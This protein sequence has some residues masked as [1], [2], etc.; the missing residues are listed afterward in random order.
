MSDHIDS[1]NRIVDYFIQAKKSFEERGAPKRAI[2]MAKYEA[3][4]R[5]LVREHERL[6]GLTRPIPVIEGDELSDLPKELLAELSITKTDELEEQLITVINASGGTA[7]ID[8]IL[9][10]LF[11]KFKVVQTRRYLQNKL[12]RMVQKEMLY[13]VSGK[14]GHYSTSI[15]TNIDDELNE[16]LGEVPGTQD[17]APSTTQSPPDVD[18]DD[19]I[20]F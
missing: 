11:R 4:L 17:D 3:D 12:W 7:D 19:I 14:K 2:E 16:L 5:A 13:S 20:P 9:I 15:S 8:T 18:D 10:Y 6:V 1:V